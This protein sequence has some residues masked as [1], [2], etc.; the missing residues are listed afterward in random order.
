MISKSFFSEAEIALRASAHDTLRRFLS[1]PQEGTWHPNGFAVFHFGDITDLGRMRLHVWPRGTR[2]ALDG[3]P[4]V[5]SH[6]WDLCSLVVAGCYLDTLYHA[7]EFDVEG[8]NRLRGY[9]LQF[10]GR[11]EGDQLGLGAVWYEVTVAAERTVTEGTVHNIAAGALHEAK[12]PL[13]MFT[14]TLLITSEVVDLNKLLLIGDDKFD[15]V[16]YVRP[17]VSAEDHDQMRMELAKV[18][19]NS[20]R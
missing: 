11:G 8:P 14:A 13:H 15:G 10:G 18:L 1:E 19:F 12:I 2:I 3:Q 16:S 9:G 6:P 5:H 20:S 17:A 4:A 7:S